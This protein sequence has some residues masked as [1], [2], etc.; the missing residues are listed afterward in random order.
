[1]KIETF[2]F[3]QENNLLY[4]CIASKKRLYLFKWLINEFDEVLIQFN[5]MYLLDNPHAISFCGDYS[6]VFGVKN[7]YFYVPIFKD[8]KGMSLNV[9]ITRF[10]SKIF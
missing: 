2:E 5:P 10:F 8:D 9:T 7:D 3:L 1:M 4:V 6:I